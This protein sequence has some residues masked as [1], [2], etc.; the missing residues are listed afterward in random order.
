MV[1]T[2]GFIA[3]SFTGNIN[4]FILDNHSHHDL[5]NFN[6]KDSLFATYYKR[7]NKGKLGAVKDENG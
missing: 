7:D 1:D 4:K 2:D 5:S 3:V 6:P